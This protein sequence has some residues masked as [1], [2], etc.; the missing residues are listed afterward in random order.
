MTSDALVCICSREDDPRE[1]FLIYIMRFI[2]DKNCIVNSDKTIYLS[3]VMLILV[4]RSRFSIP[5]LVSYISAVQALNVKI[6]G[7]PRALPAAKGD[8]VHLH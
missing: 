2:F 6:T 3:Y 5:G 8:N 1:H 4:G 7:H